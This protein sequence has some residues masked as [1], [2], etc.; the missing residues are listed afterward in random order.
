MTLLLPPSNSLNLAALRAACAK[1]HV[2][3]NRIALVE[4]VSSTNDVALEW[5]EQGQSEG[6]VV[7]AESQTAGR[8]QLGRS[9]HS[10]PGGGIWSSVLL[11]PGISP[12]AAA[13]LTPFA[14]VAVASALYHSTGLQPRLKPP[15]DL[16]YS[17]GKVCGI[18]TEARTGS[19]FFAVVGIGINVNQQEFPSDLQGRATSLRKE[20][21]KFCDPTPI[22]AEM[23]AALDRL[24]LL[25]HGEEIR[26]LYDSWPRLEH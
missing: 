13:C 6:A 9:W 22:A 10:P 8:G 17:G 14:V 11:R 7:F 4:K 12:Q 1:H 5:G 2:I 3:G 20:F 26:A 15:N 21:G 16:Y 24:Y 19:H 25:L 18:L 23:L